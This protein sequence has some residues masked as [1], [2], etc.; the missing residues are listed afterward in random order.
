MY[1]NRKQKAGFLKSAFEEILEQDFSQKPSTVVMERIYTILVHESTMHYSM[2]AKIV[3][4]IDIQIS[5]DAWEEAKDEILEVA[6]VMA[7]VIIK[8]AKTYRQEF[9]EGP[10]EEIILAQARKSNLK[11][12]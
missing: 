4:S 8:M 1:Q 7:R 5:D 6:E 2:A 12:E 10:A 11:M 3:G 9:G